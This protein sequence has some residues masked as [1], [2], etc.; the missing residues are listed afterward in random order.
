MAE[1][2]MEYLEQNRDRFESELLELL[3]IPSISTD[4]AYAGEV[5]RAA[6]WAANRLRQAGIEQVAVMETGG[7]PVVYGEWLHA[8]GKPTLLIYGHFDVQPVDPVALWSSPPFE[9]TIRDSKVF[10]RG[11]ADMKGSLLLPIFACEALLRTEGTLPVNVKFLLEAEEEIGS[12]SLEP[13]IAAHRELLACDAALNADGGNG[14]ADRPVAAI[15]RRGLCALQINVRSAKGDLHS[16]SGGAAPNSIHALVR[17]LDS[18]RSPDGRILVEGFYD[19][20]RELS[21]KERAEIAASAGPLEQMKERLG[22]KDFYGEPGFT[23]YERTV[24]R[25]TLEVNGIWG[26]YQGEGTKTVIPCEA[27]AKITCRLVANQNPDLIRRKLIAHIERVAPPQVDVTVDSFPGDALP[28]M[29]DK[30]SVAQAALDRALTAMCGQA[31]LHVR[32]PGTVPVLSML[33]AQLGVDSIT[34]GCTTGGGN[35][36]APDEFLQLDEFRRMLPIVGRFLQE[37]GR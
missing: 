24:A 23:P 20:V 19:E 25:P 5:R 3:R 33:K 7:H 2:W 29:M 17:I 22:I 6:D 21:E 4:T 9:P 30:G 18:M 14:P 12:P 11:A 15:A 10:A 31:P 36:H 26:G 28:Y 1:R 35:V 37:F 13:F 16:G 34:L 32:W 27:H 8:P